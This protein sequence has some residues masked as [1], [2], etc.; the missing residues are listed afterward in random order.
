MRKPYRQARSLAS[1]EPPYAWFWRRS[2][3]GP[4]FNERSGLP[5]DHVSKTFATSNNGTWQIGPW[6]QE[7]SGAGTTNLDWLLK[8]T[9]QVARPFAL[10]LVL[11]FSSNTNT[12]IM[13]ANTNNGWSVQVAGSTM[14]GQLICNIAGTTDANRLRTTRELHD[15]N[16]HAVLFRFGATHGAASDE[17]FVDGV[18]DTIA[19]PSAT[20]QPNYGVATRIEMLSRNGVAP[21][22]GQ[23]LAS[24]I[25]AGHIH[26]NAARRLTT[27]PFGPWRR[28]R[29]NVGAVAGQILAPHYYLNMLGGA[30]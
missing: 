23:L 20:N 13:E 17:V 21:Y 25:F 19:R 6:G 27:D 1:A 12:V 29:R 4:L 18:I 14:G 16:I 7:I 22:Q 30:A 5:Y 28:K 11:R 9:Y 3:F 26:D 2:V 15:G 8:S 10:Y 24:A